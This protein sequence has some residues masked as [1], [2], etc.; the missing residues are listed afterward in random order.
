MARLQKFYQ[1][2]TAVFISVNKIIIDV[3]FSFIQGKKS[4]MINKFKYCIFIDYLHSLEI[5]VTKYKKQISVIVK[6]IPS[7]QIILK[8]FSLLLQMSQMSLRLAFL[9]AKLHKFS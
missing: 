9:A 6:Q 7:F 3:L 8:V 2:V 5:Y 4:G 1:R